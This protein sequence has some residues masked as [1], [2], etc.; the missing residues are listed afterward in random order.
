MQASSVFECVFR[1]PGCVSRGSS[2]DD[3]RPPLNM[4]PEADNDDDDD[5]DLTAFDPF[6]QAALVKGKR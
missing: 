1:V 5:L 4:N 2:V 6:T 3:D